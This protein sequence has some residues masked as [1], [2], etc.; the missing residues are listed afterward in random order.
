MSGAE[1]NPK[2]LVQSVAKAFAVL[3]AFDASLP[4]LTVSE[5]RRARGSIVALPSA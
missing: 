4:E 5:R 3:K 2:N 1:E